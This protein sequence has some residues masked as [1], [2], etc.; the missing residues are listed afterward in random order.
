MRNFLLMFVLCFA[1]ASF[2]PGCSS[3]PLVYAEMT[4]E[5]QQ[6]EKNLQAKIEHAAR[7]IARIGMKLVTDVAKRKELAGKVVSVL[8]TVE[9]VLASKN[10]G[11]WQKALIGQTAE[12][13]KALTPEI[14]DLAQDAFDLFRGWI[15][16]PGLNDVIPEVIRDRLLAFVRGAIAGLK[17]VQSEG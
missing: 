13:L 8:E 11:D 9:K 4:Q 7:P 1:A 5:Q 10:A 3:T 2:T 6:D 17:D 12:H 14:Q 16:L 15:D